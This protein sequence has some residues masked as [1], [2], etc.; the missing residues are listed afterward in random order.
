MCIM[1]WW[2]RLA[3]FQ[4]RGGSHWC[5]QSLCWGSNEEGILPILQRGLLDKKPKSKCPK[6]IKRISKLE[7]KPTHLLPS[8]KTPA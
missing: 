1:A 2:Q 7:I 5:L 6:V 8:H 3:M 4:A